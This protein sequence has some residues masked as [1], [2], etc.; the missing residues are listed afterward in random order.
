YLQPEGWALD[1]WAQRSNQQASFLVAIR[2]QDT[3]YLYPGWPGGSLTDALTDRYIRKA[4][5]SDGSLHPRP[6]SERPP[7]LVSS[8]Y[9]YAFEFPDSFAKMYRMTFGLHQRQDYPEAVRSTYPYRHDQAPSAVMGFFDDDR[10]LDVVR[11]GVNDGAVEEI[12]CVFDWNRAQSVA[13]LD[14]FPQADRPRLYLQR[15]LRGSSVSLPGGR[16]HLLP[17]DAVLA[18]YEDG[19]KAVYEWSGGSFARME[20]AK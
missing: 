6:R 10:T 2:G 13:T 15:L 17:R 5:T 14:T 19:H 11:Y 3:L 1:L 16:E 7:R 4:A 12:V 18:T 8:G 9:G 20:L